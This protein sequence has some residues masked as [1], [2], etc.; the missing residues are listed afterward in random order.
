MG[1]ILLSGYSIIFV[2]SSIVGALSSAYLFT[3]GNPLVIF[4]QGINTSVTSQSVLIVFTEFLKL[5]PVI[6]FFSTRFFSSSTNFKMELKAQLGS[7]RP[8]STNRLHL[9][10]NVG[11]SREIALKNRLN[12]LKYDSLV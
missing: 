11:P 2:I 3:L 1:L 10:S 6:S 4:F 12:L 5:P 9:L 8:F 7:Y